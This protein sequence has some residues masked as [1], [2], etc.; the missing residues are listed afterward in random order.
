MPASR[1]SPALALLTARGLDVVVLEGSDAVGGRVRTDTVDGFTLDRGFQV[2]NT[3][4]PELRAVVD[5][6][7][8][9]LREFDSSVAVQLDGRRVVVGNPLQSPRT[10]ARRSASRSA[11]SAGRRPSAC[12]PACA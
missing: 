2:L 12:T 3:A 5:L 10:T 8:L 4:Y 11:A 6:D 7:D 9:D 1:A